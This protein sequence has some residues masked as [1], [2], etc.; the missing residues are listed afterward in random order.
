MYLHCVVLMGIQCEVYLHTAIYVEVACELK[1]IDFD[2]SCF[3][4]HDEVTT[5]YNQLIIIAV[6][7]CSGVCVCVCVCE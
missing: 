4:N 2:G 3:P 7:C 5:P 6:S 1:S